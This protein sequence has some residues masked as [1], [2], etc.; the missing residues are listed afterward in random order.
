[1]EARS[2]EAVAAAIRTVAALPAELVAKA[3]RMTRIQ[4]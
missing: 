3:A 1:V 4:Q 2:G